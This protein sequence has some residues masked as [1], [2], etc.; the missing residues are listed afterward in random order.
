ML[1]IKSNKYFLSNLFICL[2][3]LLISLAGVCAAFTE[4]KSGEP[5]GI[6]LATE[7]SLITA[8]DEESVKGF[9]KKGIT[10]ARLAPG[11][12][13]LNVAYDKD[14]NRSTADLI[15]PIN[16]EAGARYILK[17][18][19]MFLK[20]RIVF[21]EEA[22]EDYGTPEEVKDRK[23]YLD[24]KRISQVNSLLLY[25]EFL[26]IYPNGKFSQ[27][28]SSRLSQLQKERSE[29]INN[30]TR[31]M[32]NA[33]TTIDSLPD[34]ISEGTEVTILKKTSFKDG[35]ESTEIKVSGGGN[36][37][38]Y[39]NKPCLF[40]AETLKLPPTHIETL[41]TNHSI[42]TG[43]AGATLKRIKYSKK[44]VCLEGEAYLYVK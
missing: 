13:K 8:I 4:P 17:V 26:D 20:W 37:I 29:M 42:L 12:H 3:L 40:C 7:G 27:E 34:E 16:I 19:T 1:I 38:F 33:E 43:T 30:A 39:N 6:V 18:Q 22:I 36:V 32:V 24:F 35:V 25:K 5:Y 21:N 15:I 28:A 23:E 41:S 2:G 14:S 11:S 31:L 10:K 44:I 9:F